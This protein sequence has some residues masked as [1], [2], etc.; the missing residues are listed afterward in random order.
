MTTHI[1]ADI[2]RSIADG[3]PVQWRTV[4]TDPWHDFDP[5]TS[6]VNPLVPNVR[7][8]WREKPAEVK[9]AGVQVPIPLGADYL[10]DPYATYWVATLDGVRACTG[11]SVAISRY[12]K[13]RILHDTRDAARQHSDALQQLN[14][15]FFK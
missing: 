6:A 15:T 3:R 9:I 8:I 2:L 7:T 13:A 14:V 10:L 11:D 4:G 5:T 12:Q 1:N